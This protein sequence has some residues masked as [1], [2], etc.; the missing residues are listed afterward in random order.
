MPPWMIGC[1]MPNSSVMAVFT[2]GLLSIC[3]NGLGGM[4]QSP[5]LAEGADF[6][7]K[8]PGAPRLL[9]ELPVRPGA[10]GRRQQQSRVI[11]RIPSQGLRPPLAHQ[12]GTDARVDN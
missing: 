1:S 12:F 2:Q 10:G 9:M 3:R 7:F 11:Q 6:Q 4:E 8:G 5:L